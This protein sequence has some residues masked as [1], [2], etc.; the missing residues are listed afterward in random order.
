MQLGQE[1]EEG[2][3]KSEIRTPQFH[4]PHCAHFSHNY[5]FHNAKHCILNI[6]HG[7]YITF[8]F[9]HCTLPVLNISNWTWHTTCIETIY[10]LYTKQHT[11]STLYLTFYITHCAPLVLNN[12]KHCALQNYKLHTSDTTKQP[13]SAKDE[14]WMLIRWLTVLWWEPQ[15]EA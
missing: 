13:S 6:T 3:S 8:H 15:C 5:T 11:W 2:G 1:K 9:R 4:I 14:Q 7:A 12:T 10:I